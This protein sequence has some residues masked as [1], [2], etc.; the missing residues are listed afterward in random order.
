M[1]IYITGV[2]V[3][4]CVSQGA[5]TGISAS[6]RCSSLPLSRVRKHMGV[7]QLGLYCMRRATGRLVLVPPPTWIVGSGR[8]RG[9]EEAGE[10]GEKGSISEGTC[11][12]E[13]I[14]WWGGNARHGGCG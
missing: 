1:T 13:L 11:A 2:S 12:V 10:E 3:C 14:V 6:D 8:E 5:R 4:L 9:R 7:V